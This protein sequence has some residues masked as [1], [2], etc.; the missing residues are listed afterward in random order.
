MK[1]KFFNRAQIE[2][3]RVGAKHSYIVASRGV[4]KSEGIDAPWLLR[5]TF[6][7][8]RSAGA[9][10]S[11]TYG[12]LLRNTLPAVFSSLERLGYLRNV[13]YFI[14]RKPPKQYGFQSPIIN[15]FD[16]SYVICWFNGSIQHLL[17]FDRPMS[18]NSMSLDYVAGFEAKYLNYEKIVQEVLPANRGNLNYFSDCPWHH[19]SLFSTDMPT[20]KMGLWI[21]DKQKDHDQDLIETIKDLQIEYKRLTTS[22]KNKPR[23]KEIQ[24]DLVM[25]RRMATFYAEYNVFDNLEFVGDEWI[26]QQKRDLPPLIFQTAILNR[27]LRKVA[28]GFYSALNRRIHCYSSYNNQ[29]LDMIDY[30]FAK[31][32]DHRA[33]GDYNPELPLLIAMDYNAAINSLVVGQLDNGVL[34][35]IKSFFVKTPRKLKECVQDFCDYYHH[36]TNRNV[37]FYYDSTAIFDTPLDAISY[38]DT[39]ITTLNANN[40]VSENIYVGQQLKHHVKHNY[41]DRALKGDPEYPFPQFNEDNNEY[42]LIALEQTGIKIGPR[43]FEKDKSAEKEPDSVENPDETKTHITDAW[44]TLFVGCKFYP[45]AGLIYIPTHFSK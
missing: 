7:M 33:D 19:G 2:V 35:T 21:L 13:H 5:N 18:A 20:S 41:I 43:G 27:K 14:G 9:I 37:V 4:G 44:D 30:D 24:R 10:L 32:N 39:V 1:R 15:P 6:A 23:L 3:M 25:F 8:P 22:G 34:R 28:N 40:F 38:A 12:K 31:A 26:A 42:L 45:P 16:Y 11:P 36:V 29:H 17:S